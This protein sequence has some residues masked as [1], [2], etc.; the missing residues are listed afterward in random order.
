MSSLTVPSDAGVP[1]PMSISL[2]PSIFKRLSDAE[3]NS[4]TG[5]VFTVYR[6]STLFPVGRNALSDSLVDTTTKVGTNIIAASVGRGVEFDNLQDA[7]TITLQL[8]SLNN[9]QKMLGRLH[10]GNIMLL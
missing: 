4:T 8:E 3:A 6:K 1:M 7:V 9:V 5:L 10:H 2:P